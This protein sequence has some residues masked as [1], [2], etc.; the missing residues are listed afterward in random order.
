MCFSLNIFLTFHLGIQ[1]DGKKKKKEE[2]KSDLLLIVVIMAC[3]TLSS[4]QCS[5]F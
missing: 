4:L 3:M 2:K 1:H 5:F